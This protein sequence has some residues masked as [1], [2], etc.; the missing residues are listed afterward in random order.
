MHEVMKINESKYAQI[1][2]QE[3]VADILGISAVLAQDMN[4]KRMNGFAF[5]MDCMASS[6]GDTGPYPQYSHARLCSNIRKATMS[7]SITP[8]TLEGANFTLLAEIHA[9]AILVQLAYWPK[10]FQTTYHKTREPVTVLT[11]LSK[12]THVVN[13][14][15]DRLNVLNAEPEVRMARLALYSAART[16]L[17]NA[18]KL[19]GLTTVES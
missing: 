14:S 3:S 7:T 8:G 18:M 17:R 16:V 15:Y 4:S 11:Y 10:I 6:E 12:L 5:D 19:L 13:D 9:K 1:E 2:D